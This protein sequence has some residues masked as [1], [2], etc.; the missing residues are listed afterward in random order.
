MEGTV[1]FF[2]DAKGYGFIIKEDGTDIFFHI[3]DIIN[4]E[5]LSEGDKVTY[6]IGESIKGVK[7]IAI[8]QV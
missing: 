5:Y 4:S 8:K 3:S 2:N 7:A 6:D 1:K